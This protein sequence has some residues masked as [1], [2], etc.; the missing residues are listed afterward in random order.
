MT[1]MTILSLILASSLSAAE[2]LP[3][4]PNAWFVGPPIL[5]PRED[6]FDAR[7]VKDPTV[8]RYDDRWHVFYTACGRD[9]LGIAYVSAPAWEELD[10]APRT[11]LEQL[12]GGVE[13]YAA[14]PQVFYFAPQET[15]Y[16]V[17]QTTDSNYQPVYATTKTIAEPQSWSPPR[18][19]A[20]KF[21]EDK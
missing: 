11:L 9:K 3:K 17:Y 1:T 19:L 5:T 21:E 6:G 14:A 13:N 7:A 8:V 10:A 2:P 15:W 20:E 4:I 12:S 16:L 18:P